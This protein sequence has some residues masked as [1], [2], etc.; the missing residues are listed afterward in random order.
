MILIRARSWVAVDAANVLVAS[1]A[2][3]PFKQRTDSTVMADVIPSQLAG[4][5]VAG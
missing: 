5:W 1:E 2:L 4:G 3:S